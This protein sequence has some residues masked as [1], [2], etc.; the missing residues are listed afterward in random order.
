M[1]ILCIKFTL[2][3]VIYD[4]PMFGAF[5]MKETVSFFGLRIARVLKKIQ[6]ALST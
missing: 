2:L 5:E 4:C 1:G 6:L 3:G